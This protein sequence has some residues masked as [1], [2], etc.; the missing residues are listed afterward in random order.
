MLKQTFLQYDPYYNKLY[1][2]VFNN[3]TGQFE[4]LADNSEL[5]TYMNQ[6]ILFSDCVDYIVDIIDN[7]QNSDPD[8]LKILFCGLDSDYQLLSEAVE[9]KNKVSE[10][11]GDLYCS[12][13]YRYMP[14]DKALDTIRAGYSKIASEFDDYLPGNEKYKTYGS[15]IGDSIV[16][17]NKTVS[18]EIPICIIGN[19]SVGK[20]AFINSLIGDELLPSAENASTAKNVRIEKSDRYHLMFEYETDNGYCHIG[21]AIT[22]GKIDASCD[23]DSV[24]VISI[25]DQL[26]QQIG[27]DH[28]EPAYI[29]HDILEYFNRTKKD[30]L[31]QKVGWNIDIQ[32]PFS[33][34]ILSEIE[35]RIVF[36]DT[37]GSNNSTVD[38]KE[39]REALARL[40]SQQTNALP[41]LVSTRESAVANDNLD[42]ISALDKYS[43]NF[44]NPSCLIVFS[45]SDRLP[46]KSLAEPIPSSLRNWH[47]KTTIMY[48]TPVGALGERKK[49]KKWLD[50]SYEYHYSAWR[51]RQN[52]PKRAIVLPDYNEVPCDRKDMFDAH[53]YCTSSLYAT[54]IPSLE[55][56]IAYYAEHYAKSKKCNR[57]SRDLLGAINV[58]KTELKKQEVL[59]VNAK[60]SAEN[61]KRKTR[62]E[63]IAQLNQIMLTNINGYTQYFVNK[64]SSVVG[65]YVFHLP[66][67]AWNIFHEVNK[68]PTSDFDLVFD[69][70]L[71]DN[72]QTNLFDY[73]YL[74]ENGIE[75]EIIK[76]VENEAKSFAAKMQAFVENN[77][78]HFSTAGREALRK[79]LAERKLPSI[80]SISDQVKYY[81][82]DATRRMLSQARMYDVDAVEKWLGLKW[83]KLEREIN[84]PSNANPM[85][86]F[87]TQAI[88]RPL[89]FY[90]QRL[91]EW[92]WQYREYIISVLDNDN[93]ILSGMEEEIRKLDAT[94]NDLKMRLNNVQDV[95][96]TLTT[97]LRYEKIE[98]V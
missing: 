41:I 93:S 29:I 7:G 23:N 91:L 64:Y 5:L 18:D 20:S 67:I 69:E 78:N 98:E 21:L 48:V 13:K 77:D 17:F 39:H 12:H 74:G 46:T 49:T 58:V 50:N 44:T 25:R 88:Q 26:S 52:D 60:N 76:I 75:S 94:V 51:E 79:A 86:L 96:Q 89:E 61:R 90:N 45:K 34:S 65:N 37:P 55:C 72:C 59:S 30:S 70:K 2:Q 56:E 38:E 19:Y 57:G 47:G 4:S 71:R 3:Q 81:S 43:D 87:N 15:K 85:G 1:V 95:E 22:S 31:L 83:R 16:R 32:V 14:A 62:G 82:E 92:A 68:N 36:Y 33:E 35:A 6:E 40:M 24:D 66:Q 63:L 53:K 42:V 11:R 97:L 10:Q 28:S 73:S 9:R 27:E 8:G 84:A 80:V 54:G